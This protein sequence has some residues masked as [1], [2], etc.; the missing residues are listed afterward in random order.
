M[1]LAFLRKPRHL[2]IFEGDISSAGLE[3]GVALPVM[4]SAFSAEAIITQSFVADLLRAIATG[5]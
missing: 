5:V 4:I 1:Q 2:E 3:G